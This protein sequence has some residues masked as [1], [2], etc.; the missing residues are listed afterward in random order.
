MALEQQLLG[1]VPDFQSRGQDEI[2]WLPGLHEAFP[3]VATRIWLVGCFGLSG[4]LRQY[5]SLY[6][7]VSQREGEREE[8]REESKNVQTTPTRTYCKRNRPLPYCH[9]NCRTPRHWKF[10]QDH[11]TTRPPLATR[12]R[13]SYLLT[14]DLI[15]LQ[16]D[17]LFE[18][19]EKGV[20]GSLVNLYLFIVVG[21][22]LCNRAEAVVGHF[23]C[24]RGRLS[25]VATAD[26]LD[27]STLEPV[28]ES[29]QGGAGHCADLVPDDHTRNEL[30][31]H[32]FRRPLRLATPSEEAV[33]GLGQDSPGPHL[34][35]QSMGRGEDEGVSVAEE[36]DCSSGFAAV[37][38]AA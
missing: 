17:S 9:P 4:T 18:G 16:A 33:I 26:D 27:A 10:I 3:P 34:F 21:R 12:N 35:G 36:L 29:F 2:T 13:L 7:S 28:E 38:A 31:P 22:L 5:F 1:P 15:R 20:F 6:R 8:R 14:L 23:S 19:L 25:L 24:D 11:R 32:P 30:L 37:P